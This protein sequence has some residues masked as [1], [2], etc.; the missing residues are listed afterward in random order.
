MN[1]NALLMIGLLS[2][3]L[4]A[5]LA[6]PAASASPLEGELPSPPATAVAEAKV[7]STALEALKSEIPDDLSAEDRARALVRRA[8]AGAVALGPES[9]TARNLRKACLTAVNSLETAPK[10][11]AL[12]VELATE[13]AQR[14]LAFAPT[15]EAP[16]PKG[17]PWPV[18]AGEIR[19]QEYPGYRK[20][21]TGMRGDAQNGAFFKLFGHISS[22][23]IAMTAPVEMTMGE[24]EMLDMAFLYGDPAIGEAGP[25]GRVEVTD[26]EPMTVLS[27]G[28]R[29]TTRNSLATGAMESLEGWLAR[30][31]ETW[32]RAGNARLMGYNGPMTPRNKQYCEVQIPVRRRAQS[33]AAEQE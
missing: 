4:G 8:V 10:A 33:G 1:L 3:T 13:S 32:E 16:L 28:I 22:N 11:S 15:M 30:N 5:S 24:E 18:P 2:S 6:A 20:V 27:I 19:I 23:D 26:I 17:F 7:R 29:G 31:S 21:M 12:L 14:D 25:D 9:E